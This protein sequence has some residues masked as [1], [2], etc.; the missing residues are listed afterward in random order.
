MVMAR[1]MN[2]KLCMA[3]GAFALV[4]L[5]CSSE[6]GSI[7][8]PFDDPGAGTAKHNSSSSLEIDVSSSSLNAQSSSSEIESSS[9]VVE[10]SSSSSHLS[11]CKVSGHWRERGCLSIPS[12]GEGDLW[13]RRD[14]KVRTNVYLDDSSKFGDRA[15]EF[16]FETDSLE[17]GESFI[18]WIDGDFVVPEFDGMLEADV[19]FAKGSLTCD[20]FVKIGFYVAG[21]DS[22]GAALS[23][24]VTN[25]KG[26]C[27]FYAGT[28]GTTLQLDLGD[29]L[30]RKLGNALPSVKVE[31]S[32]EPQCFD[33]GQFK[34]PETD[35]EH[36]TISGE[37]AAKH[38]EKVVFF[39]QTT[40][41]EEYGGFEGFEIIAIGTNRDE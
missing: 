3:L 24:D 17:G 35:T 8:E 20:P 23:A 38:V 36:E 40:P 39:F 5:A 37:E 13:S 16:F 6:N 7:T 25:W 29:A 27:L 22:S 19:R 2:N 12:H 34:Q 30:N 26:L 32:K 14:R 11:L 41:R 18:K 28:I 33:W 4:M 21:F 1:D 31:S 9:S 15:G 10:S